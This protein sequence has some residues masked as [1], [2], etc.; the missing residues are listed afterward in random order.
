MKEKMDASLEKYLVNFIE[1]YS[2][3]FPYLMVQIYTLQLMKM[4]CR[5]GTSSEVKKYVLFRHFTYKIL[6]DGY[7]IILY[8]ILEGYEKKDD[9][10]G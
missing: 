6:F 7:V 1:A 9:P 3:L 10:I 8:F 4:L 5:E 2:L